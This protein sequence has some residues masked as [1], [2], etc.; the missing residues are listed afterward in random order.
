MYPFLRIDSFFLN[1]C[2]ADAFG[3]GFPGVAA[4]ISSWRA[5]SAS[6]ISD[7]TLAQ[8][9]MK[10]DENERESTTKRRKLIIL[11]RKNKNDSWRR[12]VNNVRKGHVAGLPWD[13]WHTS[14]NT[15]TRC[16]D[17]AFAKATVFYFI[18]EEWITFFLPVI[19]STSTCITKRFRRLTCTENLK[20]SRQDTNRNKIHFLNLPTLL[21]K[22]TCHEEM[23][24]DADVMPADVAIEARAP[25][26]TRMILLLMY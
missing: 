3:I 5:E 10:L 18:H 11:L 12:L 17:S 6:W 4:R 8:K 24:T 20:T 1:S 7:D 25:T 23:C 16:A 19:I 22:K 14:R 9:L 2:S 21:K 26:R 13:A 15:Q